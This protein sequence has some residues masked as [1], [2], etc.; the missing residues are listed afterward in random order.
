MALLVCVVL[1]S[2]I[3]VCSMTGT[4]ASTNPENPLPQE[5]LSTDANPV[6]ARPQQASII[7]SEIEQ[8]ANNTMTTSTNL[9]TGPLKNIL[10]PPVDWQF[11]VFLRTIADGLS[12]EDLTKMKCL[13]E[14]NPSILGF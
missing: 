10:D 14:G 2:V 6:Q 8:N 11:N 3:Y 9:R 4:M 12:T 13:F 5:S 7:Q 1:K